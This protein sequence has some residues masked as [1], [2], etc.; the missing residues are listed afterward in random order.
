MKEHNNWKLPSMVQIADG[1]IAEAKL[2]LVL[3]M[4]KV[5]TQ[6]SVLEAQA[7][8]AKTWQELFALPNVTDP[9]KPLK[10]DEDSPLGLWNPKSPANAVILFIYQM[11]SFCFKELNRSSRVKDKSKVKTLGP[12]AA[13]LYEIVRLA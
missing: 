4:G 1:L 7:N 9:N 12:W 3:A 13:A 10:C 2:Q 5:S 11:D 8:I 6:K